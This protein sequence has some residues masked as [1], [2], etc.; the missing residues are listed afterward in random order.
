MSFSDF[1][2]D[3]VLFN[4][5]C[6]GRYRDNAEGYARIYISGLH[7]YV[8]KLESELLV[9]NTQL[10][11]DVEAK[12]KETE[13]E[14]SFAKKHLKLTVEAKDK[15]I[16][17]LQARLEDKDAVIGLLTPQNPKEPYTV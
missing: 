9:A 16:E 3:A 4:R 17:L 5:V 13:S 2:I 15:E 8:T 6:P 7:R 14:L 10:K 12:A 1:G 11:R